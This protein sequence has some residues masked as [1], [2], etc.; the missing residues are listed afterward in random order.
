[1]TFLKLNHE[2]YL[3]CVEIDSEEITE[4]ERAER[5]NFLIY[6]GRNGY[7][8]RMVMLRKDISVGERVFG[9]FY[10]AIISARCA[11]IW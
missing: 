3:Y 8:A 1:M 4:E 6:S 11:N 10:I 5:I 9:K 7:I 2:R